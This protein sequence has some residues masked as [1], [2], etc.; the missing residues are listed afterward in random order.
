MERWTIKQMNELN[1]IQFAR[2][3]LYERLNKVS[4]YSPLG[5]KLKQAASDL[6]KLDVKTTEEQ[7]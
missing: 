3:I 1:S 4:P 5:L 2:A 6:D 7:K